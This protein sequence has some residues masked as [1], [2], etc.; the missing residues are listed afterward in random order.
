[1]N[2][3]KLQIGIARKGDPIAYCTRCNHEIPLHGIHWVHEVCPNCTAMYFY[4]SLSDYDLH[5]GPGFWPEPQ[6]T[7]MKARMAA[8]GGRY[9]PRF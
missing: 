6:K 2:A 5:P 7:Q 4:G 8:E 3:R 1:M 9:I